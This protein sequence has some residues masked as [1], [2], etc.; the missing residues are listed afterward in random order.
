[1]RCAILSTFETTIVCLVLLLGLHACSGLTKIESDLGIKGAPDWVNEGTQTVSDKKGRLIQGVGSSQPLGDESLQRSTADQR[2]RAEVARILSSYLDV[3]MRDYS[4]ATRDA[5]TSASS[6]TIEQEIGSFSKVVLNGSHIIGHW[7]DKRSGVIY[8]FAEL[9]LKRID[10][11]L[12]QT[13]RLS[14]GIKD[15]M[16]A[17]NETLFD[18]YTQEG[19]SK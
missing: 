9:D 6:T 5:E 7:K 4:E 11:L 1:M 2:A 19:I 3:V 16:K 14:P 10:E 12:K 15:Y 17:H 8:A 18:T 13:D